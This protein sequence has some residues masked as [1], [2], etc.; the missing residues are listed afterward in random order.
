MSSST[1]SSKRV[2]RTATHLGCFG[3]SLVA[4]AVVL[5]GASEALVRKQVN[6]QDEFISHAR[7]FH[8]ATSPHAAFG[9][10]HVA[11]GLVPVEG[12][13]NLAYP[14]EGI[15]HID[16]KVR[17]YFA[18]RSPGRVVLQADPHLLAP[19][20]L[21]NRLG[22]YPAKINSALNT[23][24]WRP[25]TGEPRY[26]ANLLNYWSSYIKQGGRLVS[27]I[28]VMDSGALL[29]P[30]DL[31][32]DDARLRTFSARK[33][34]ATHSIRPHPEVDRLMEVYR[35]LVDFLTHNGAE[36]CLVTFPLSPD[37]LSAAESRQSASA[38][39]QHERVMAFFADQARKT[40]VRHA[41]LRR[42]TAD[43]SEFR[44]VDH[45]NGKAAKHYARAILDACYSG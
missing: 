30:G 32:A 17:R 12:M 24:A 42:L 1:S 8:S 16:W 14:S 9:D 40:G 43:R 19:Y 37:Y 36:V 21:V 31:S 28:K 23:A 13:V 20:R 34:I 11:R 27:R 26:R 18:T 38:K 39:G 45:L 10:S 15:E 7:L 29:S 6:P 41:D 5:F 2:R 3:A 33:R 22:N 4:V 35:D 25:V 44:D